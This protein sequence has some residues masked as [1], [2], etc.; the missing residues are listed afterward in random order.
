L[1][2]SI[3]GSNPAS[4]KAKRTR[5]E[6]IVLYFCILAFKSPLTLYS[7][8]LLL[9]SAPA[10]KDLNRQLSPTAVISPFLPEKF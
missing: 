5:N 4:L 9:L 7:D 3:I 2:D 1:G 8:I 6:N 10:A